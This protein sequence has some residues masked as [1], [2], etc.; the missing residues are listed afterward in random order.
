[1][2]LKALNLT[3][4]AAGTKIPYNTVSQILRGNWNDPKRLAKIAAW[5]EK[6]NIPNGDGK[7]KEVAA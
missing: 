3:M 1:M 5:I 4:V 6:Q 2:E 7:K